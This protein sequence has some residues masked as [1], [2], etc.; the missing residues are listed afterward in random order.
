MTTETTAKQ[1]PGWKAILLGL[2][3]LFQVVYLPLSNLIQLVPREMPVQRG[4]FDIRI[5]REGTATDI[6]FI[7]EGINGL[8]SAI[9]RYGEISGQVQAWSLF[10]PDFGKQSIFPVMETKT[11]HDGIVRWIQLNPKHLPHD[12]NNY[13][14]WPGQLSRLDSYD[15]LIAIIY[16]N[17][18]ETSLRE[19]REEWRQAVLDRVRQ[20]QRSLQAYFGFSLKLYHQLRPE[21]PPPSEMILRVI[22]FPTPLPGSRER[23]PTFMIPLARWRPNTEPT[24]GYLPVEA[25]DLVLEKFVPLAT[26]ETR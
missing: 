16:W 1:S 25:Y 5:Q 20:Q 17:A 7:Q 19:R 26:G 8:G 4:E 23:P 22:V 21:L 15:F 13:F 18:S 9:D 6:R 10:A 2:F 12:P 24:P 11:S 3:V 14:R